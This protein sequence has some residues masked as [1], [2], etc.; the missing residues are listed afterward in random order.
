ME[1][2]EPQKV[3]LSHIFNEMREIQQHFLKEHSV[4]DI[5]SNSKIFEVVQANTLGHMMIPGHSGTLDAK[6][7]MGRQF[8]YKHFKETSSNHSWTFN[9]YSDTTILKLRDSVFAVIFAHIDDTVYPPVMDWSYSVPGPVVADYLEK[10]TKGMTNARRMINISANQLN[11]RTNSKIVVHDQ[12]HA[13]SLYSEELD[14]IF[15]LILELEKIVDV[16][17]RLTSTKFWEVLVSL[18][19]GHTV[20]SE[21]G[22]RAGAHD[23]FD[24]EG[25]DYE[26]KVS[27]SKSWNFQDISPADLKKYLNCD[28]IVLAIVDKTGIEVKDVWYANP[29]KVVARLEEKLSSKARSYAARGKEV[30]RQQVSISSGDLALINARKVI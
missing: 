27:S 12:N 7:E 19:L 20:N 15:A 4:N 10:F 16:T 11:Q 13:S 23:A 22:G 25:G 24:S 6:D 21:Q 29:A 28:E 1:Y 5:W 9:D 30:R 14:R 26:Y 17:N 3:K 2:V 18:P 8:E